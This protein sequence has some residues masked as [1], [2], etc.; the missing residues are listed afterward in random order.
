[1]INP[2]AQTFMIASRTEQLNPQRIREVRPAKPRSRRI[3]LFGNIRRKSPRGT[4]AAPSWFI[5]DKK[6]RTGN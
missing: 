2:Y 3:A 6:D 5:A 4:W 1:M